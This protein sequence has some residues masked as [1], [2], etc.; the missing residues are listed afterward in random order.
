MFAA[1][2]DRANP[3]ELIGKEMF[4]NRAALKLA[5]LDAMVDF[6]LT[7]LGPRRR[8][9]SAARLLMHA[10]A[11]GDTDGAVREPE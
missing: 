6:R 11:T 5:E 4:Q 8:G 3:Y 2:R 10:A 9:G 1:A 7:V